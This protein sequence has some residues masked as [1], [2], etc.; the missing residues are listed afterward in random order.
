M[1]PDSFDL[2]EFDLL[3]ADDVFLDDIQE[4]QLQLFESQQQTS[5]NGYTQPS[6]SHHQHTPSIHTH[7]QEVIELKTQLMQSKGE[8]TIVR[9]KLD[10]MISENS[11]LSQSMVQ[12]RRSIISSEKTMVDG[13][14]IF[15]LT[16]RLKA[17]ISSLQ[18]KLTFNL[19][20]QKNLEHS[21]RQHQPGATTASI[22]TKR[23]SFGR[24]LTATTIIPPV[25]IIPPHVPAMH[26]SASHS[27][28]SVGSPAISGVSPEIVSEKSASP[29][30]IPVET[31][32]VSIQVD[33]PVVVPRHKPAPE[34]L[35]QA[36]LP[37]PAS[38][39]KDPPDLVLSFL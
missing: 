23:K 21:L 39:Q 20:H 10:K 2:D 35:P 38:L 5:G 36:L 26:G 3:L 22:H 33:T 11:R 34:V 16:I 18:T 27:S 14:V 17:E 37:T 1:S 7:N 19:A 6:A 12:E 29:S 30:V 9:S 13:Y 8:N 25:T 4:Q 15:H 31:R 24:T 28:G 32:T